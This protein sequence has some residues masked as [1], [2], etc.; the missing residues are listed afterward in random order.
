M[1]AAFGYHANAEKPYNVTDQKLFVPL[2]HEMSPN[3]IDYG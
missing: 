3:R 2:I 1:T